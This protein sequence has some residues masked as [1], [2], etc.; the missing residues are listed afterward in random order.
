MK[1][2]E[3][4]RIK[5]AEAVWDTLTLDDLHEQFIFQTTA[6]YKSNPLTFEEDVEVMDL[7]GGEE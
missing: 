3:A 4:N 5:L 1:N 2:T 6:R 7:E